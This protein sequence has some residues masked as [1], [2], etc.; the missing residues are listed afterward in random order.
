MAGYAKDIWPY[1]SL[2]STATSITVYVS[3]DVSE[4][5][6]NPGANYCN[7][8]CNGQESGKIS[9]GR[10]YTFYG[11]SPNTGYLIIIDVMYA[12]GYSGNYGYDSGTGYTLGISIDQWSWNSSELNAFNN[13][14]NFSVLTAGR[15]NDFCDRINATCIAANSSWLTNYTTLSGAKASGPDRKSVV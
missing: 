5:F 2:S 6:D 12:A 14:G 8:S 10:S 9:T 7:I 1:V 11:L 15:W 4:I 13:N 3:S